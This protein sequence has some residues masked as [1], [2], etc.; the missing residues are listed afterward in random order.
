MGNIIN[1]IIEIDKIADERL[2]NAYK[3]KDEIIENAKVEA[4]K[5][6]MSLLNDAEKRI[7]E[8]ENQNKAEVNMKIAELGK[9]SQDEIDKMKEQCSV[10]CKEIEKNLIKVIVGEYFERFI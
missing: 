5:I 4:E 6:K 8:I 1:K 2:K 3:E 9:S 10:R 7:E